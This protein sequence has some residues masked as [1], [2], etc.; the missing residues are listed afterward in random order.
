MRVGAIFIN[1]CD[2]FNKSYG[3]LLRVYIC[4]T[5]ALLKEGF[6]LSC[7]SSTDI[8]KVIRI[9][10]PSFLLFRDNEQKNYKKFKGIDTFSI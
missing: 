2:F 6:S 10:F 5:E 9:I 1:S 7:W 8:K 3:T 4:V